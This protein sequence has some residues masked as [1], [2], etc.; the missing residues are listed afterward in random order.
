MNLGDLTIGAIIIFLI[1]FG[2]SKA[3]YETIKESRIRQARATYARES[4]FNKSAALYAPGEYWEEQRKYG[5]T[6]EESEN[7]KFLLEAEERGRQEIEQVRTVVRENN[8]AEQLARLESQSVFNR[9]RQDSGGSV[10]SKYDREHLP[11]ETMEEVMDAKVNEDME[12][13]RQE[14]AEGRRKAYQEW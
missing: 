12:S 6:P 4:P 8:R 2:L 14:E 13:R 7:I 3:R 10:I 9:M 1:L 5:L 11:P